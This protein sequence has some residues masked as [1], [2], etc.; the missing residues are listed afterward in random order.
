MLP[1]HPPP[2]CLQLLDSTVS[3]KVITMSL[4]GQKRRPKP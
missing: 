3:G 2:K 4:A 1:P